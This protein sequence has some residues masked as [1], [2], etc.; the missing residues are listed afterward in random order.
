MKPDAILL[1]RLFLGIRP[2]AIIARQ[3][4]HESVRR[5]GD[6]KRV[7][8]DHQHLTLWILNDHPDFPE[9]VAKRLI[10]AGSRIAAD[11]FC[12]VLDRV[13]GSNSSVALRSGHTNRAL[14]Q[15]H[16]QIDA[17]MHR[18]GVMSREGYRFSPHLTLFYRHGQP[19]REAIRAYNW[20]V[21]EVVLIHSLVGRKQHNVLGRWPLSGASNDQLSL[22]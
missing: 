22:F 21:E 19:F 4:D 11:P 16:R 3:I 17:I 2:P 9:R 13:V 18:A 8:S 12:L 1:H 6:E 5:G 7:R 10:E 14:A 15:L 20:N